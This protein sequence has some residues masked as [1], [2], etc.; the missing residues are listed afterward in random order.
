MLSHPLADPS[1]LRICCTKRC[2]SFMRLPCWS[3]TMHDRERFFR[4]F[5]IDRASHRD[6]I[7][8]VKSTYAKEL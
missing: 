7:E 3:H 1:M 2:V 4:A 5:V 8:F 6:A